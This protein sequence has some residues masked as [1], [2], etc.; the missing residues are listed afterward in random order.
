M[1]EQLYLNNPFG[2]RTVGNR[3]QKPLNV[4]YDGKVWPLPP[5]PGVVQ[6][7]EAVAQKAI[8]QHPL[9][10][11]ED[12]ANPDDYQSLVYVRG[13]TRFDGSPMPEEPIEQNTDACERID[14][15]LLEPERR[16]G[17]EVHRF[18]R[19]LPERMHNMPGAS[20]GARKGSMATFQGGED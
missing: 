9:L 1:E 18:G 15:S 8:E 19:V 2:W 11:S 20:D 6:M 12:P 3:T 7:P 10:G 13:A 14:T 5:Y 16:V 17:R 4:T